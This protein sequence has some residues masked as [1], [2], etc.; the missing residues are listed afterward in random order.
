MLTALSTVKL[1]WQPHYAKTG[2]GVIIGGNVLAMGGIEAKIIGNKVGRTTVLSIGPTMEFLKEK[3]RL[4]KE[5]ENTVYEM[6]V[7]SLSKSKGSE[8]LNLKIL[9]LKENNLK[10]SL[11]E[12]TTREM[13][14]A[15]AQISADKIYPIVQ[16][17]INN[18]IQS[19]VDPLNRCRVYLDVKESAV[20]VAEF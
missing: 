16:V 3:E 18:I 1:M 13:Q 9:Q 15:H 17:S 6:R 2:R 8:A 4:E 10:K 7:E 11:Q 12:Y 20:K 14:I 5:L 19:I